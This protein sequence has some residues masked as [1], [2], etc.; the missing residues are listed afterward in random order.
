MLFMD[1][2]ERRGWVAKWL[3]GAGEAWLQDPHL[4]APGSDLAAD[5]A[6]KPT[7]SDLVAY[8]I[9]SAL[10]HL[11][12]VVDAMLSDNPIRHYA[13]FTTLR[14]ALLASSRA[15]WTLTPD[16]STERK[17]RSLQIRFQNVDEQRK[18]TEAMGGTHL[19]AAME[20]SRQKAIAAL[21]AE[22]TSLEG[23]AGKLGAAK[24]P[25]PKDTVSMLQEL[26]DANSWDGSAI[27]TQWRTG[28][29]AAH[30]YHW[31]DAQRA[32]PGV[33]DELSFNGALYG[34]FLSVTAATTLFEKRASGH[35]GN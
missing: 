30:G 21:N 29:A 32:N 6:T 12:S 31:I 10:D 35:T 25:K 13:H 28:S 4:P 19:D 34:A 9:A 11:G 5:D 16:D 33:F 7:V 24:L 1:D 23:H 8:Q 22:V 3:K 26:V 20:Q 14:T 18:A 2:E 17:L 27:L 15:Q